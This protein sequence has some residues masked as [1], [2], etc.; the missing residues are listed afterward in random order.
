[1]PRSF[2]FKR[3]ARWLLG[4]VVL[5]PLA[6]MALVLMPGWL[7]Q[8]DVAVSAA[9]PDGRYR[10]LVRNHVSLDPPAQSLWIAPANGDAR[11]VRK[12]SEDQDWCKVVVW[13]ANATRVAFLVQDARLLVVDP[14]SAA[15]VADRWLVDQ[16]GYPPSHEVKDLSLS[17]DGT[18]ARFRACRRATGIC[19][20]WRSEE[21]KAE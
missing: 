14:R 5:V 8:R 4:L 16:D 7:G 12:L 19:S 3:E 11:M 6:G 20:E 15:L 10:A 21:V 2:T 13:S 9:S 18:S 17:P 1:M